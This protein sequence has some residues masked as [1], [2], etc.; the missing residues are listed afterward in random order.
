M[1]TATPTPLP[2]KMP[3]IRPKMIAL[4]MCYSLVQVVVGDQ[5]FVDFGELRQF[6]LVFQPSQAIRQR[7]KG[8]ADRVVLV[9]SGHR[10][11]TVRELED[12]TFKIHGVAFQLLTDGI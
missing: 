10:R 9:G 1:N 8:V 6:A 5:A 3:A 11:H 2:N 4:V 12:G 7:S